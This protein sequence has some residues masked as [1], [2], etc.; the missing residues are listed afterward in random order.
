MIHLNDQRPF[1]SGGNRICYRHPQQKD[2]CLKVL[3]KDR[4]PSQRR[5]QK[6]FPANL[7]KIDFFDENIVEL[8]ALN[9]LHAHYPA[10]IRDHLPETFGLIPTD[11]GVAHMT[12]LILDEDGLVSQTLEQYIWEHGLNS[13]VAK[14]IAKFKLSW[15]SQT[16]STRD[17]IPHNLVLQHRDATARLVLID[18]FGRKPL[19]ATAIFRALSPSPYK[20]RIQD[21]DQRIKRLLVRRSHQDGPNERLNNLVR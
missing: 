14:S 19:M 6:K 12:S 5:S 4:L 2:R 20:R 18:G 11:K 10:A 9:Y 3:R 16:P 7:R 8:Q 17:L 1:A 21:L 13:V 15:R